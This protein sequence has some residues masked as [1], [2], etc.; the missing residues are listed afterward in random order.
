MSSTMDVQ[1]TRALWDRCIES[2][3]I[4][5][6]DADFAAELTTLRAKLPP[7]RIDSNGRLAEWMED[8]E[9]YEIG[10]RHYSHLFGLYPDDQI[11]LD[12]T[13]ELAAAAEK[14][15]VRRLDH[16]GA[17]PCWSRAWVCGLWA[18]LGNGDQM[19][20]HLEEFLR[21]STDLNLF[22]MHPPQGSN[23]QFV[24]Q[25]DGN[26]GL[27][28][29]IAEGLMQSQAG[30][31]SLLPAL[32]SAWKSGKVH[33][34]RARGGFEVSMEWTDGTL[35]SAEIVSTHGR[36]CRIAAAE[37]LAVLKN[38]KAVAESWIAAAHGKTEISVPTARGDT[39][40]LTR[41]AQGLDADRR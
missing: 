21:L 40:T 19:H 31:I 30:A 27:T 28:A 13:P 18:R 33:G 39:I 26:L 12:G 14:S 4:L 29:A 3:T 7:N 9:E 2:A 38:G 23:T 17:G 41:R 1:I 36:T 35:A 25:L 10:H 16:G 8:G 5:G 37:G 34:L 11:T 20:H 22:S 24:F 15:L 6:I 32:P